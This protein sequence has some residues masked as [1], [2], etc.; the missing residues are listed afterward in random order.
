MASPLLFWNQT[1]IHA[2]THSRSHPF[3]GRG[4]LGPPRR[5]HYGGLL[6]LTNRFTTVCLVWFSVSHQPRSESVSCKLSPSIKLL[7]CVDFSRNR[8]PIY[9]TNIKFIR[10]IQYSR[11]LET[12]NCLTHLWCLDCRQCRWIC[13]FLSPGTW[14]D[15]QRL[16][17]PF[18][19]WMRCP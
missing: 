13:W 19:S 8:L 17:A 5:R 6:R 18:R 4:Q 11:N 10:R 3:P 1:T 9:L 15:S 7:K 2:L 12:V 16:W 14:R